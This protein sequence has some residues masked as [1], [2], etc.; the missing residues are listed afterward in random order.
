MMSS[1]HY[2]SSFFIYSF[3][4]KN[5]DGNVIV[6]FLVEKRMVMAL[7][8]VIVLFGVL[9]MVLVEHGA[10]AN[11]FFFLVYNFLFIVLFV[12]DANLNKSDKWWNK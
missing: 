6:F 9:L 3:C 11:I 7:C 1:M 10:R 5:D 4:E 8:T 12:L 2:L